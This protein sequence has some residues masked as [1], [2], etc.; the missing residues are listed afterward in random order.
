M[1]LDPRFLSKGSCTPHSGSMVGPMITLCLDA[2]ALTQG[3]DQAFIA[4][5][6]G[7]I[8]QAL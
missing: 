5:T 7:T 6:A 3:L 4:T 2:A 1:G 8:A